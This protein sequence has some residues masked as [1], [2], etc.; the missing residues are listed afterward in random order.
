MSL[1]A[2]SKLY[3]VALVPKKPSYK[4]QCAGHSGSMFKRCNA[5]DGLFG[6]QPGGPP[7]IFAHFGVARRSLTPGQPRSSRLELRE[8]RQ[9]RDPV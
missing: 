4:A 2:V 3:G 6:Y 8:I 1:E 7:P 5:V 9:R